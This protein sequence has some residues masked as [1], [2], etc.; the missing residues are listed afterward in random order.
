MEVFRKIVLGWI[1]AFGMLVPAHAE[2]V[3]LIAAAANLQFALKDIQ[4]KF[5]KQTGHKVKIVFGS[6]GN[7]TTQIRQGAPFQ[8][9]MSA[10][11]KSV[12]LIAAAGL[13]RDEG[14]VYAQGQLCLFVPRQARIKADGRLEGLREALN[15]GQVE[16]FAIA[17]PEHAP[18]GQAAKEAL[19]HAGVWEFINK[20]LVYGENISQAAQFATTPGTSGGLIAYSLVLSPYMQSQGRYALIPGNFHQPLKQRMALIKHAGPTATAFYDFVQSS[21]AQNILQQYG[22]ALP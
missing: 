13:T 4:A 2:E 16:R 6:S 3:P 12:A 21:A 10:D 17:N 1:M 22:F 11:E 9:F 15:Q 14:L 8:M 7:L 5:E 19:Q 18:Y 20:R